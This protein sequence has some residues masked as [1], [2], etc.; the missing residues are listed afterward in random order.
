MQNSPTP[1]TPTEA[2]IAELFLTYSIEKPQQ[3][4][5]YVKE[6]LG[7]LTEEQ[8]W[9]RSSEHCNSIGN[10]LLHLSGNMRQWIVHGIGG[11][12]DIRKREAEFAAKGGQSPAEILAIFENTLADALAVLSA[13]RPE[14]LTERITPQKDE[15]SVLEAIYQ[16]VGH[17]QQHV[18]QIVFATKQMTGRD[19]QL[20]KP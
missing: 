8:I 3:M 5:E 7:Q 12:A 4:G 13:L 17:L 1:P 20:Y 6:C 15:V 14:R 9:Q 16:V 10:L 2:A 19:L 11:D 18:G